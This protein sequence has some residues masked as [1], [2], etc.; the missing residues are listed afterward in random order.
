MKTKQFIVALIAGTALQASAQGPRGPQGPP[1]DPVA[2]A[3]DKNEDQ[4]LSASEIRGAVRS[5]LKLDKNKDEALSAEELRP[6][7]PKGARK[8]KGDEGNPPPA[9]PASALM[10]ILDTDKDGELSKD[11]LAAAPEALL[12][13]DADQNGKLSSD[14]A[15]LDQQGGPPPGGGPRGGGGQGGGGRPNGP[16]PGGP[17]GPRR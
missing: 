13:L 3:L 15:G 6:E 17:N 1:P 2:S 5:L 7:P 4:K 9:P 12:K 11:E 8:R 14:E 10:K 16:P